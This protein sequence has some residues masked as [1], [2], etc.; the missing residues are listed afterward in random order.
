M[1]TLIKNL[2]LNRKILICSFLNN[3]KY[4]QMLAKLSQHFQKIIVVQMN[5]EN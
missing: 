3:K 1:N 5:E 4:S 2:P